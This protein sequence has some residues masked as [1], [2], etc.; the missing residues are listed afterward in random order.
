MTIQLEKVVPWGRN[1]DEYISMF[2]LTLTDEKLTILDC[3]G[4]PAS[5]NC[6]MTFPRYNVI[7]CD[8]IYQFTADEI[9]QCIQ[10]TSENIIDQVKANSDTFYC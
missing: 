2:S 9:Y 3:A 6:E 10:A 7:S 5:F 8:P 1:L 4:G